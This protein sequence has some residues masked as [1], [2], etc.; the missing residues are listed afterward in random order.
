MRE[1][2]SAGGVVFKRV[3][4]EIYF[5]LLR[6]QNDK[7]TFPKGMVESGEDRKLTAA[8]EVGEETGVIQ[9]EFFRELPPIKY[10]YRWEGELIRK[11]VYYFLFETKGEEEFKP[12]KEEGIS[13]VRWF[14]PLEAWEA[15]GYPKTNKKILEEAFAV[16]E[17]KL[18]N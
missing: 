17:V 18:V 3:N 14:T 4:Q 5:L 16:F 9:I 13:E 10:W 1:E 7:L 12:Q 2:V 6:D 15:V 11:T 8:R